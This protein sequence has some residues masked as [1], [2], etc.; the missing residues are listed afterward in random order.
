MFRKSLALILVAVSACCAFA[1]C[2]ENSES[3]ENTTSAS[4]ET[5]T[6]ETTITPTTEKDTNATAPIQG[7]EGIELKAEYDSENKNIHITLENQTESDAVQDNMTYKYY[8]VN[9]DE[10]IFLG[11]TLNYYSTCAQIIP[12]SYGNTYE[13]DYKTEAFL[14]ADFSK[15]KFII[16]GEYVY[17]ENV[18]IVKAQDTDF[19]FAKIDKKTEGT[20][21]ILTGEVT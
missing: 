16:Q 11:S 2:S 10:L 5:T 18:E 6:E 4:K 14:G 3:P 20:P 7:I 15:D 9:G 12:D 19:Y 8:K 13:E 21:I 17:Y 1:G